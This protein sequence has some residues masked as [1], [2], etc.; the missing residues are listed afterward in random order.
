[1]PGSVVNLSF[2]VARFP[3]SVVLDTSVVLPAFQHA[4]GERGR[5]GA[6]LVRDQQRAHQLLANLRR[7]NVLGIVTPTVVAEYMHA[8]IRGRYEHAIRTVSA[9]ELRT[10]YGTSSRSW[11]R[12]YKRD[13][14]LMHDVA[15]QLRA[16]F[17]VLDANGIGF[18]DPTDFDPPSGWRGFIPEL[19][20][21]SLRFSLDTSDARILLEAQS[22]GIPHIV[23]LDRDMQRAA[24]DFTVYTWL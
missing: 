19:L 7:A 21:F 20:D 4:L 6:T 23:T 18:L 15:P 5:T 2:P 11:T 12:L 14:G 8:I 1:M 3:A 10:T 13:P 17:P 22:L 9:A 24:S 16:L